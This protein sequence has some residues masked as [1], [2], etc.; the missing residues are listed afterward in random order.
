MDLGVLLQNI[1]ATF[2]AHLRCLHAI[3]NVLLPPSE[4]FQ[5]SWRI[6]GLFWPI[7]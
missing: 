3:G 5:E 2:L 6:P 1:Y 7:Y 4:C